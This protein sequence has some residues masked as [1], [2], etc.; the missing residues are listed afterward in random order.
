MDPYGGFQKNWGQPQFSS[1]PWM[2]CRPSA[3]APKVMGMY[4]GEP[5][6]PGLDCSGTAGMPRGCRG[7]GSGF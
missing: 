7:F 1:S 6:D 2:P 4:P 5:G 3:N